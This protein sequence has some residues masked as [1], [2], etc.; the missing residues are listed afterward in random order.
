MRRILVVIVMLAVFSTIPN[1]I[2]AVE[3]V[4][5][6]G[7]GISLNPASEFSNDN[8]T[9]VALLRM[10]NVNFPMQLSSSF[11]LEPYL[12]L[13][14]TTKSESNIYF[15]EDVAQTAFQIGTGAFYTWNP[16][17]DKKFT[18]YFGGR[19]G[20]VFQSSSL[21]HQATAFAGNSHTAKSIKETDIS[22][23]A[24]LGGEYFLSQHFSLGGEIQFAFVNQG[25]PNETDTPATTN[26]TQEKLTVT[27]FMT[28]A[29]IFVRLY[30]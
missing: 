14:S 8:G 9:N 17:T 21:D 16:T 11:R 7:I 4:D 26:D 12:G 13:Y 20:V 3:N 22:I 19:F 10:V 5:N 28:N 6:Y 27:T 1:S 23:A 18:G 25:N 29:Q 24:V 30:F 2:F 15:T